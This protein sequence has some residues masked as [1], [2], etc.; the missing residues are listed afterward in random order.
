MS[1]GVRLVGTG[2][3]DPGLLTLAAREAVAEASVIRHFEGCAPGVL[4]AAPPGADVAPY[5]G[6]DDVLRIAAGGSPVAVLF[7]GDPFLFS[8]GS[9]LAEQLAAAGIDVD[10]IPGLTAETSAPAL[11][12]IPLT[13]SGRAESVLLGAAGMADTA[14]LRVAPAL[15][16]SGVKALLDAGHDERRPA[17]VIV[18]PGTPSQRRVAAPLGE[19]LEVAAANGLEGD[20]LIVVGPGAG[21]SHLLDTSAS[22]PLH[23]RRVLVT[24]APHQA[25]GFRRE[26]MTLGAE[27]IEVPTIEIRAIPAGPEAR[28]VIAE[29]PQVGLVIFT[30]ANAVEIFFRMLFEERQDARSFANA[31]VCAIG[32]ETARALESHGLRPELVAGEYT[33]EG[34][35]DVLGGWDLGGV[36]VLVPRARMGRDALPSFLRQRGAD[37][38]V[39]AVYETVCPVNSAGELRRLFAG[40]GVDVVTFTSSSTVANFVKAF[41]DGGLPASIKRATIACMGPV[42]AETARRLGLSV[43]IIAREYT[44]R[45]LAAA[46]VDAFG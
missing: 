26:L 46:I 5:R 21:M 2:P 6:A 35:A 30:S 18:N 31:K 7:P 44:T 9:R 27:V 38:H 1:G 10:I 43:D 41:P 23:G 20:A 39:L 16:E 4:A 25:E 17:A 24:R 45:G 37:V 28:Q 11:S 12:G 13:I 33:A 42:T 3:G 40:D 19:L 32:P 15:W 8:N 14:V 22:R 36:R 34:L 29:L